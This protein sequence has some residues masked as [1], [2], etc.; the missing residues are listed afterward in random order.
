MLITYI[1]YLIRWTDGCMDGAPQQTMSNLVAPIKSF[2]SH[3][4]ACC[5]IFFP[6]CSNFVCRV[7][8]LAERSGQIQSWIKTPD[9]CCF[10]T[11]FCGFDNEHRRRRYLFAFIVYCLLFFTCACNQLIGLHWCIGNGKCD[12]FC[13]IHWSLV[14]NWVSLCCQVISI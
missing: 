6:S 12:S 2:S 10:Y 13:T 3:S 9:I 5:D 7:G 11:F 14:D 4:T 1:A 8:S